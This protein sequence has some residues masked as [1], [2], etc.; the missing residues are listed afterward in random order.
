VGHDWGGTV[1]WATAINHP[2]VVDRLAILNVAH[3]RRLLCDL[4]TPRQLRKAWYV[5]YFQLPGLPEHHVRA[6]DC[7]FFRDF[8]SAARRDAYTAPDIECYVEAWSHKGRNGHQLLLG[9]VATNTQ[10]RPSP[11]SPSPVAHPRHL[12][13]TRP[14]P[15]PR[16]RGARPR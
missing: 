13:L 12:R 8:L 2:E 5:L 3:T 16:T 1:A 4:R 6:R 15:R 14:L 7:R 11:I 9:R 10:A